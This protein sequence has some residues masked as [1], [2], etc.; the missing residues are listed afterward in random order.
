MEK[1]ISKDNKLLISEKEIFLKGVAIEDPVK[2][3]KRTTVDI[4]ES[5]LKK[6]NVKLLRIPIQP[7]HYIF[8]ENYLEEYLDEW[9]DK[10]EDLGIYALIDWHGIGNPHTGQTR[11][12][13]D[14]VKQANEKILLHESDRTIAKNAWQAISKRY[15]S[16]NHVLFEL[17]NEPAP[18]DKD[19]K[20]ISG[21]K[22]N[23]WKP[24]A[25]EWIEEIRKN[26]DNLIVV[27]GNKWAM[28][29][30]QIL[31]NPIKKENIAYSAHPYPIHRE[32]KELL[33][34]FKER[35]PLII[36][37]WAFIEESDQK[38]WVATKENYADILMR[39][40]EEKKISW[41]AWCFSTV[42]DPKMLKTWEPSEYTYWGKYIKKEL[43]K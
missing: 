31:D 33:P 43:L 12:P 18:G 23:Q 17:F 32:W 35:L 22:W 7:G 21:L 42:W 24:I 11:R 25:E 4:V 41:I 28:G 30:Q 1:I 6:L 14:I 19:L 37:E 27:G 38:F 8:F 5:E 9:I 15:G 13:E 10:C 3:K 20:D 40:C 34:K 16:R 2:M 36:T 26:T 29:L 39:M